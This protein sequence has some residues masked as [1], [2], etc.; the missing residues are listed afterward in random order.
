LKDDS[1]GNQRNKTYI[2]LIMFE[3]IAN[4]DNAL[5][6]LKS[7]KPK[8]VSSQAARIEFAS[9]VLRSD[10][11][12]SVQ[13]HEYLESHGVSGRTFDDCFEMNDGDEVVSAL[14]KAASADC[15][16]R[17]G[18]RLLG[19]EVWNAWSETAERCKSQ[20]QQELF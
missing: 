20:G 19:T 18:I 4:I 8:L 5:L 6:K 1:I 7:L 17:A 14:M 13:Q 12:E 3:T 2:G 11:F 15:H 10:L 16:L 9:I